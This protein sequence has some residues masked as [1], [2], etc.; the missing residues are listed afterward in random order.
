MH[1]VLVIVTAEV[2]VIY[3]SL[4]ELFSGM[5][6]LH[7]SKDTMLYLSRGPHKQKR[8]DIVTLHINPCSM[9]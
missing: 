9:I 6:T 8:K 7:Q 2:L 3:H 1:V 4:S 5:L